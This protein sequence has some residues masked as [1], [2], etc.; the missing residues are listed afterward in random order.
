MSDSM[1]A[2]NGGQENLA[3]ELKKRI[4]AQLT[5][6]DLDRVEALA[7][8]LDILPIKAEG[9]LLRRSWTLQTC[10][11]LIDRLSLPLKLEVRD[12]AA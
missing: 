11:W 8:A 2:V 5:E 9:L 6:R 10:L 4:L 12:F 3:R 1:S 7:E